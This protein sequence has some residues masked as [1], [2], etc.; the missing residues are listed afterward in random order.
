MLEH[1]SQQIAIQQVELSSILTSIENSCTNVT[2]L[3]AKLCDVTE[4]TKEIKKK[5]TKIDEDLMASAK[6][7]RLD[8]SSS[9]AHHMKIRFLSNMQAKLLRE[10]ARI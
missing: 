1:I 4:F 5:L 2:S 3:F 7:L 8:S 10:E 9:P 6:Q